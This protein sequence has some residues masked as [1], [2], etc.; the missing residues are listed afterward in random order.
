MGNYAELVLG[1][2]TLSRFIEE[3]DK[4]DVTAS[5]LERLKISRQ[6]HTASL[7]EL[8]GGAEDNLL[9]VRTVFPFVLIADTLKIDRQKLTVV[10]NTLFG[11][12][13]TVSIRLKDLRNVEADIG[14]LFG[15]ITLTS[16]HFL[17]NT[18]TI[19]FL[20]RKDITE[21]QRLLQ[22]FMIAHDAQIDTDNIEHDE[23]KSLLNK[24]GQEN[25]R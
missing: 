15:S 5:P 9:S 11:A 1:K 13:Q 22:G 20:K 17:N 25:L 6:K 3:Q 2:F 12:S 14:P 16:Q 24:L 8:V 23:L 4:K 18:Q 10:H 19:K 21:A 7:V